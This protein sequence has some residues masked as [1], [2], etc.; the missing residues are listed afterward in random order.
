MACMEINVSE[1]QTHTPFQ[2]Y[3]DHADFS[4]C[5]L[6]AGKRQTLKKVYKLSYKF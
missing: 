4:G 2:G 1:K 6:V 3:Q 5:C